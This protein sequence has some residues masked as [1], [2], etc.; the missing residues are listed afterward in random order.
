MKTLKIKH[1]H[2]YFTSDE[3]F[4]HTNIIK[5][6]HRPYSSIEEMNKDFIKR[7]NEKVKEKN[8]ITFHL[9][10]F[11]LTYNIDK[12]NSII[13]KLN[14]KHVFL[15]G[16]HDHWLEK[17]HRINQDKLFYPYIHEILNVEIEGNLICL[18]HYQ[19]TVWHKS[20]YNSF[21]LYGHAHGKSKRIGRSMDVGVDCWN[22][23]PLSYNEVINLLSPFNNINLIPPLKEKIKN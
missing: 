18:C 6:C 20:H 15:A 2:V 16:S 4:F 8:A 14:G 23:Y 1:T 12:V 9:G 17:I 5:Y 22:Y 7:F 13:E 11:A 19:L 3:H 21:H 10:D